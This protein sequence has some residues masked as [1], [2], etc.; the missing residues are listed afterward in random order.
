VGS[1]GAQHHLAAVENASP[2]SPAHVETIPSATPFRLVAHPKIM[3][4]KT[5]TLISPSLGTTRNIL[6]FHYGPGG[7]QKI[8]I[9]S[10]LHA[11]CANNWLN[12]RLRAS[13]AAKW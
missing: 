10:S 5:H 8:Y 1:T 7:G 4:T 6:S 12:S 11:G 9:Q 2:R 13:C 3:Q